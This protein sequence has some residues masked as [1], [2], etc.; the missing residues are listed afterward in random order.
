MELIGL[1]IAWRFKNLCIISLFLGNRSENMNDKTLVV[2]AICF[3]AALAT[4]KP[5]CSD[6]IEFFKILSSGL[7]GLV[8]GVAIERASRN[9]TK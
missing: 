2:S 9:G 8:T 1:K 7:F 5:D 6:L 4:Y 3:L